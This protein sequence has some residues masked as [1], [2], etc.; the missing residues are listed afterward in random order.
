MRVK[1][2]RGI[3]ESAAKSGTHII[4]TYCG[5]ETLSVGELVICSNCENM[6]EY[7]ASAADRS[8]AG[9]FTNVQR[10][11]DLVAAK[12]F[13]SAV[14]VWE[15]IEW[16]EPEPQM[17]YAEALFYISYSNYEASLVDYGLAGFMEGNIAHREESLRLYSIAKAKLNSGISSIES[18]MSGGVSSL[19]LDYAAFL[20][21][22]KLDNLGAAKKYLEDMK[23]YG[24]SYVYQYALMVFSAATKDYKKVVDC[25]MG[26]CTRERFSMGAVYYLAWGLFKERRKSQARELVGVLEGYMENDSLAELAALVR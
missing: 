20:M 14:R 19:P 3:I 4:C 12:D 16:A 11:K 15:E 5:A 21:H 9:N 24:D 18:E 22:M 23:G 10:I 26:L 7:N 6:M 2:I 8:Y 25:A 1:E 13:K 17:L